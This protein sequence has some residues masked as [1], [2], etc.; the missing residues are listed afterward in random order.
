MI[1]L[2]VMQCVKITPSLRRPCICAAVVLP[3]WFIFPA[4]DDDID[5]GVE[6]EETMGDMGGDNQP[7]RPVGQGDLEDEQ[8]DNLNKHNFII[9]MIFRLRKKTFKRFLKWFLYL[10]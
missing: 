10:Y 6:D 8:Q 9:K 3:E 2:K 4:V 7:V 5:R 1:R